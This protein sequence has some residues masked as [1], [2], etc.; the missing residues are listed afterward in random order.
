[1]PSYSS[2]TERLPCQNCGFF[3]FLMREKLS[4]L[5]AGT[6]TCVYFLLLFKLVNES[7]FP[8]MLNHEMVKSVHITELIT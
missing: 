6:Q 3:L 8:L 2:F 7:S 5:R 4:L 1:M